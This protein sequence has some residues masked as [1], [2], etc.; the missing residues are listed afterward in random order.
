MDFRRGPW[1]AQTLNKIPLAKLNL[2]HCKSFVI[3]GLG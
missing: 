3:K 2:G 1:I